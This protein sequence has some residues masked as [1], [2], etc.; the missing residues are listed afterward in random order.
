L[1]GVDIKKVIVAVKK[2]ADDLE[3]DAAHGGERHDRGARKLREQV[4]CYIA[5]MEG[6][7]P[8]F[9]DQYL[10]QSDPEW[11]EYKRLRVKFEGR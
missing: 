5:G 3:R 2:H 4:E 10:V 6:V 8:R 7:L 11:E 9:W 1:R